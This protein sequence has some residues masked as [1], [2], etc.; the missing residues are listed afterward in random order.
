MSENALGFQSV[1][2]YSKYFIMMKS[3][4]FFLQFPTSRDEKLISVFRGIFQS[5]HLWNIAYH[6][7]RP[8]MLCDPDPAPTS[9]SVEFG[10]PPA[11]QAT[12]R[13]LV[14]YL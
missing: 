12:D 6:R 8:V 13:T 9:R 5:F 11:E 10:S 2:D 14:G 7:N 4:S 3:R 1:L